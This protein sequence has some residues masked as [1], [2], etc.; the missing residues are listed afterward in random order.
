MGMDGT[1]IGEAGS[2][3]AAQ[4]YHLGRETQQTRPRCMHPGAQIPSYH[5]LSTVF[6]ICE[7]PDIR[8]ILRHQK[9]CFFA[10]LGSFIFLLP[11]GLTRDILMRVPACACAHGITSGIATLR[12]P[13]RAPKMITAREGLPAPSLRSAPKLFLSFVYVKLPDSTSLP[14]RMN[15]ESISH[16]HPVL[17]LSLW[18]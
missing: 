15:A 3:S 14:L 11:L 17:C 6:V 7:W 5:I 9:P 18:P 4:R 12:V 10:L 16:Y 2:C 1:G 13:N 8:R